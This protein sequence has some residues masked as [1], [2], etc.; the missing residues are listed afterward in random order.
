MTSLR[1]PVLLAGMLSLLGAGCS[2]QPGR[3]EVPSLD[4][5]GASQ[6][7]LSEFDAD[8]DGALTRKELDRCP[9]LKAGLAAIDLDKDGRLTAEE[10]AACL[11][12][13][14]QTKVGL[15]NIGAYVTLDGRAVDGAVVTLVPEKFLGGGVQPA[16]GTTDAAGCCYFKV[17]RAELPGVQP[18]IYRIEVS[19]KD[20][21]GR[22][23]IP[24]RYNSETTLGLEVGSA[25]AGITREP[26]AIK[27]SS[28]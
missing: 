15:W 8:R 17:E 5:E 19:K 13:Y 23:T 7:A 4:P 16:T 2:S 11:R 12:K 9:G 10:I 22:E 28:R 6:R 3:I 24:P 27:L 1:W 21:T 18:G 20:A 26:I 25:G 14:Q